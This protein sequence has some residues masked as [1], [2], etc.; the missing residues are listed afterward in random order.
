MRGTLRRRVVKDLKKS[1]VVHH[2]KIDCRSSPEI[3]GVVLKT[4]PG[5]SGV[6]LK[7]TPGILLTD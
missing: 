7:T 1:E 6:V 2:S 3:P 5:I 4:T